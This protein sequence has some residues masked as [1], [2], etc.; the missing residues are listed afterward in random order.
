MAKHAPNRDIALKLME[1]LA[2]E[3]AQQM[4]TELNGEYA[5]KQGIPLADS[6]KAWGDFKRDDVDLTVVASYQSEASEMADR[7]GYDY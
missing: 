5:V 1:F 2:S 4:S 7:I 6:V 3:Y